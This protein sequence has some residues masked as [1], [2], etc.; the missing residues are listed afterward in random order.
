MEKI[1]CDGNEA[2]SRASY[3]FTEVAGIYPITPSSP[4]PEL[5]DKWAALGKKNIFNEV[6]KVIEMQSET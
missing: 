3:L 2:C 4:M 5:I 6:P 1:V